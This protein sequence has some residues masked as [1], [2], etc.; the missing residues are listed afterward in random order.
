MLTS[1]T[2]VIKVKTKHRGLWLVT[3]MLHRT[4]PFCAETITGRR[5]V[6]SRCHHLS[7]PAQAA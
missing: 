4:C 6:C 7:T 5:L 3:P 1:M 2:T